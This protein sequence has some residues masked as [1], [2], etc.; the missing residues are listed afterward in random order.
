MGNVAV[1]AVVLV[2]FNVKVLSMPTSCT[3]GKSIAY[4]WMSYT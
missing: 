2:E 1:G 4:C 3:L